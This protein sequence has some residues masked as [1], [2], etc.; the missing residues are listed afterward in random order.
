MIY[1]NYFPPTSE[2]NTKLIEDIYEYSNSIPKYVRENCLTKMKALYYATWHFEHSPKLQNIQ[3]VSYRGLSP[4]R[5]CGVSA[6]SSEW[7]IVGKY[8]VPEGVIHYMEEHNIYPVLLSTVDDSGN[9]VYS[10]TDDFVNEFLKDIL[11]K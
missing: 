5:K 4:C 11:I 3:K 2:D 7:I 8:I 9:S 10:I 1:V 6:G